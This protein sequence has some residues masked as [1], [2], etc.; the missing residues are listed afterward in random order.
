[1]TKHTGYRL[2]IGGVAAAAM[3]LWLT[4]RPVSLR[5]QQDSPDL[6]THGIVYDQATARQIFAEVV[7]E[8]PAAWHRMIDAG[9]ARGWTPDPDHVF[10]WEKGRPNAAHLTQIRQSSG[11]F[12]ESTGRLVLMGWQQRG[13]DGFFVSTYSQAYDT[14]EEEWGDVELHVTGDNDMVA[15]YQNEFDWNDLHGHDPAMGC[16]RL[17]CQGQEHDLALTLTGRLQDACALH[18]Q[19]ARMRALANCYGLKW[20][21][22]W[23]LWSISTGVSLLACVITPP[24]TA[25]LNNY[26][27][28][29]GR[30]SATGLGL[31][32]INEFYHDDALCGF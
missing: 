26:I 20:T 24:G 11:D 2:V 4:A 6:L 27:F 32:Y 1:M 31:A 21:Q 8:N 12:S 5:A 7:A 13:D 22:V 10:V 15:T 19:C 28:C 9:R 17:S 23:R 16:R 3:S 14:T 29:V 30:Q 25:F 18:M